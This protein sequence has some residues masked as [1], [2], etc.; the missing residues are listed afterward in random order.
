MKLI[1]SLLLVATGLCS[2]SQTSM[3]VYL[4]SGTVV[5]IPLSTIDSIIYTFTTPVDL[6]VLTT[7]AIGSITATTAVSGGD[8]ISAGGSPVTQRGVCWSTSPNP[9]SADSTSEDGNGTGNF[10]S[11]LTGLTPGT[12]Y[13]V[14]AYAANSTGTAYGN[15]V[16]FITTGGGGGLFTSGQGVTDVSGN[17]YASIILNNGQEWMAENLRTT[18]YS[19]GDPIPNVPGMTFWYQLTTGAWLHYDNNSQTAAPYGKLYNYHT[20]TDPRN[21]CPVG[22]HVPAEVEWQA[23]ELALGMSVN[24]L[25]NAGFRGSTQNV[26]GSM[27]SVGGQY[28]QVPNE[29]ATNGSGF[30]GL[31]SG[32]RSAQSGIFDGLGNGNLF[33]TATEFGAITALT[34]GLLFSNAGVFRGENWK[35]D[36]LSVRCLRD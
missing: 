28:W 3:F 17:P 31:P 29:G 26:G 12:V 35:G 13:Y 6:A 19:N 34:R 18:A 9:T 23:L 7:Q 1:I 25:T 22:W 24:E 27:K 33:W 20:V 21:V 15:Q 32:W 36:G 5:E 8:I 2:S 14:R 4:N 11:A 16:Q 30:S 10:N